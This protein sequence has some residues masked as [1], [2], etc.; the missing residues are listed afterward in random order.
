VKSCRRQSWLETRFIPLLHLLGAYA[1][2]AVAAADNV[3]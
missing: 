2:V 1:A 3:L